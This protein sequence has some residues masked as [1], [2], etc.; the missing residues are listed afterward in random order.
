MNQDKMWRQIRSKVVNQINS[1]LYSSTSYQIIYYQVLDLIRNKPQ[2]K[3]KFAIF[4]EV[5]N[6]IK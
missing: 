2:N 4:N 5:F 3:V 6:K 1:Q